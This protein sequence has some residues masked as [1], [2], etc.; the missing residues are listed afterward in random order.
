M[1]AMA[2]PPA[3]APL[4]S[5]RGLTVTFR[6]GGR[7]FKAVEDVDFDVEPGE[8]LGLVGESG[9]GKTT[10]GRALLRLLPRGGGDVGGS[11]VYDGQ[12]LLALGEGALRAKRGELQMIFQDPVSSFNPRRQVQDI[13]GEGLEIRGVPKAERRRLVEAALADVGFKLASV[14]GRRPH[15]FSGGQCQRI[16]I[17][18]AL[19]VGP[20]LIVCDEPVASLDVSVQ[21][22]VLNLLQDIR[23]TRRLALIF[24]SHDLAVVRNVSDRVAV[25]YMGRIVEIGPGDALYARPAHP[26]TR[27][28][29]E[30]VPVPDPAFRPVPAVRAASEMP[31]RLTPPSGCRFRTR[32]PRAQSVCAAEEPKLAP[33]PRGQEVA[34]HFPHDE[35]APGLAAHQETAP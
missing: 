14:E 15:Q 21:A 12:D 31:S 34:C 35:P 30:A 8:T 4:L 3:K 22:Q 26:Y 16:A 13:V 19:A 1:N 17:A 2:P 33:G 29:L 11:I 32:C 9:S 7:A 20:R 24:I 28:L 23:E 27:M 25:L 10:I 6:R 5:V 18:R